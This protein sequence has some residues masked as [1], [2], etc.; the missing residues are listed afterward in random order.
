MNRE[1]LAVAIL[2]NKQEHTEIIQ[3]S[4]TKQMNRCG[5]GVECF[6]LSKAGNIQNIPNKREI[7][8]KKELNVIVKC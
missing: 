1:R 7:A 3:A 2:N 5:V 8:V 4:M 6:Y